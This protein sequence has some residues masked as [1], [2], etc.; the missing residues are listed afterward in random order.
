MNSKPTIQ[1]T[2]VNINIA[3][4]HAYSI[5]LLLSIRYSHY[6]HFCSVQQ[7]M[8]IIV[9]QLLALFYVIQIFIYIR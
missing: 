8:I 9:G 2:Y 1:Y 7:F 3:L 5:I 6:F 4:Q